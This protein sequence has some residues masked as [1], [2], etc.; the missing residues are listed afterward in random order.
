MTTRRRSSSEFCFGQFHF[1]LLYLLAEER[2]VRLDLAAALLG[3]DPSDLRSMVAE[4]ASAG[5]LEKKAFLRDEPAKYPWIWMTREALRAIG[6][7]RFHHYVPSEWTLGHLRGI[8]KIRLFFKT[9]RPDYVWIP[10]RELSRRHT[11][12]HRHLADG[13]LERDGE[14]IPIEYE[15]TNKRRVRIVRNMCDLVDQHGQAYFF[16]SKETRSRV[17]EV[18]SS[19][20]LDSVH[21]FDVPK[22]PGIA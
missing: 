12:A 20:R 7:T 9:E 1:E 10:E 19:N 21:V 4:S 5:L 11:R 8:Q 17:E 13:A 22:F 14:L 15:R 2:A 16:C 3:V 6:T 18:K